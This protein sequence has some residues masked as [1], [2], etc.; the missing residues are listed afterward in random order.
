V[1]SGERLVVLVAQLAPESAELEAALQTPTD[2]PD[3]VELLA[4][5]RLLA[6]AH[7]CLLPWKDRIPSAAW[8]S[9]T[10]AAAECWGMNE[11]VAR[12]GS[13]VLAALARDGVDAIPLKGPWIADRLHH[14]ADTRP[15]HDLDLLVRRED[16]TAAGSRLR[17]LGYVQVPNA[18]A[19]PTEHLVYESEHS[20]QWRPGID[21]HCH[22]TGLGD[23]PWL[24]RLWGRVVWQPFR[25]SRV[26]AMSSTD[27]LLYLS[28]HSARHGWLHLCHFLDLAQALDAEGRTVDW[29]LLDREAGG[30]HRAGA[31]RLSLAVAVHLCG[32]R[33]PPARLAR[34]SARTAVGEL[35]LR[36]RGLV[37]LRPGLREGPYQTLL[38]A[39]VDDGMSRGL[40]RLR[41]ATWPASPPRQPR[42]GKARMARAARRAARLARQLTI[43]VS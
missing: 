20:T 34:P 31:L 2:W 40:R 28:V 41:D 15:T 19:P 16:M 35:M 14:P 9:L 10:H 39:L 42:S 22:I 6:R 43:A 38:K 26:L 4:Y 12:S 33:P 13:A 3:T 30:V 21:I 11:A 17:E 5:H 32:A 1:T 24:D 25:G 8:R 7:G 29:E 23:E 18:E 36:R 27:L 37:R